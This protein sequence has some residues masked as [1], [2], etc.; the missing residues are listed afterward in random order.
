MKKLSSNNQSSTACDKKRLYKSEYVKS[1]F[2]ETQSTIDDE[3]ALQYDPSS[4]Y[5]NYATQYN[6]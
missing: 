1:N 6:T 5:T 3:N 2:P 4:A